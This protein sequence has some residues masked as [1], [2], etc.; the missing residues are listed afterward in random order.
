MSRQTDSLAGVR[1]VHLRLGDKCATTTTSLTFTAPTSQVELRVE[2]GELEVFADGV[3]RWDLEGEVLSLRDLEAGSR[4]VVS[5][6]S[7]YRPTPHGLCRWTD[8]ADGQSYVIGSGA[9]GG[10]AQFMA[11]ADGP[12]D[13]MIT[14]L[15]VD[16]PGVVRTVRPPLLPGGAVATIASH[17]LGLVAGPWRCQS[18]GGAEVLSRDALERPAELATLVADTTLALQWLLDWFGAAPKDSPWGRTYTQ[19][20]LPHAPWLA[21]EHPGCVLVSERLLDASRARRVAVVAHEAAHQ[22]LGNLVS[23]LEWP[24]VGIFEGLAELL[25][26]LACEDIVGAAAAGDLARRR[27]AGPL[28]RPPVLRDLRTLPLTAGLAAVAGPVQHAE[29]FRKVRAE[30]GADDFRHRI[31]A[32]VTR[33]AGTASSSHDVWAALGLEPR[34]PPTLRLPAV[35]PGGWGPALDVSDLHGRD[36]ASAAAAARS[37]FRANPPGRRRVRATLAALADPTTPFPVVAGLTEELS[38]GFSQ[39]FRRL[40]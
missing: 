19:A 10:A 39:D 24:D 36:P 15:S 8:P 33:H 40:D 20:L 26:Q 18:E 34:V 13:R 22:W 21:M 37:A 9:L 38:H 29:L 31:Q 35:R 3:A 23:P 11:A 1:E 16:G 12:A 17:H 28:V 4:V 2:L 5:G 25:G 6:R 7:A 32:L 30:L 27:A 14:S